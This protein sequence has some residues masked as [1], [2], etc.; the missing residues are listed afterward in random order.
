MLVTLA[1]IVT[2]VKELLGKALVHIL[3]TLAG[4]IT[5][6]NDLLEKAPI[7]IFITFT[8]L[9]LLGIVITVSVHI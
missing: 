8:Q 7:H 9:K 6:V 5:L 1:G 3:V 4:I 2:L